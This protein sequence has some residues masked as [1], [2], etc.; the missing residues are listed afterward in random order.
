MA[1]LVWALLV[2]ALRVWSA[3]AIDLCVG[4]AGICWVVLENAHGREK[5]LRQSRSGGRSRPRHPRPGAAQAGRHLDRSGPVMGRNCRTA[6]G[7]PL[8]AR[9]NPV[10]APPARG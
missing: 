2:W 8:A 3:G 10:A 5:A 9:K 1:L 7:H 4:L 6:P